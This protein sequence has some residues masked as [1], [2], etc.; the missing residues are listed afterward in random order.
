MFSKAFLNKGFFICLV[1]NFWDCFIQISF[2]LYKKN[3]SLFYKKNISFKKIFLIC[4]A[5][6]NI[7]FPF[8]LFTQFHICFYFCYLL[9][10]VRNKFGRYKQVNILFYE[11]KYLELHYLS[12]CPVS[13]LVIVKYFFLFIYINNYLLVWLDAWINFLIYTLN[14]L[15]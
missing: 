5:L 15:C 10:V 1:F 13:L 6:H 7:F 2:I 9:L 8:I 14:F 11:I 3:I 12:I 4:P